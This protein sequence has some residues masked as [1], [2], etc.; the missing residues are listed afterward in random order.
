MFKIYTL[1]RSPY[2]RL[3]EERS[4]QV[5]QD[6][7]RKVQEQPLNQPQSVAFCIIYSV[8]YLS[9]HGD[10]KFWRD[11]YF[12]SRLCVCSGLIRKLVDFLQM[13]W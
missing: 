8:T 13:H 3:L 4:T 11:P 1:P 2:C 7:C 9:M 10:V 12:D 5:A 6:L